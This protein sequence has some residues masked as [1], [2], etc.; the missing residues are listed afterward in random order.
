[1]LVS[2]SLL[3]WILW[4]YI[5]KFT[6]GRLNAF[7]FISLWGF[8]FSIQLE[9]KWKN[10]HTMCDHEF[11]FDYIFGGKTLMKFWISSGFFNLIALVST[12]NSFGEWVSQLSVNYKFRFQQIFVI[13]MKIQSV[14]LHK[15]TA[16]C[17]GP[18]NKQKV[19]SIEINQ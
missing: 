6:F 17:P 18:F 5:I 7:N 12:L 15:P 19:L 13:L 16:F 1:M 9:N 14:F 4:F 2:C 10:L 11:W 3:L 8:E